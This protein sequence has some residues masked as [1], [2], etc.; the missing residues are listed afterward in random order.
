MY[1]FFPLVFL[2]FASFITSKYK[3]LFITVFAICYLINFNTAITD[4][5]TSASFIGKDQ[6]SWKFLNNMANTLF[7][8][9]DNNFGYFVYTPDVIAYAP[10]YALFYEQKLHPN[11]NATYLDKKPVT[12]MVIAPQAVDN[13]YISYKWWKENTI[14]LKLAPNSV[15]NF[16]N[17]YTIEKYNL[18]KEEIALPYDRNYDPGLGFR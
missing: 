13:P 14:N 8:V 16:P 18:T 2:I 15:I 1:P 10:K 11:V 5:K 4:I 17:G 6:T 7:S 9:K 3:V 12:Y